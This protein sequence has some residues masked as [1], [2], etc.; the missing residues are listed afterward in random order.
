[1]CIRDSPYHD[2]D[3]FQRIALSPELQIILSN[4][5]EAGITYHEDDLAARPPASFPAQ[6]AQLLHDRYLAFEGSD[7]AG[8]AIICC[9]LIEENGEALRGFVVR[10][11]ERAGW[12]EE[13][14]GW[15]QRANHFYDTL[16]DRI[17]SGFPA[18]DAPTLQQEVGFEDRALVKGEFFSLWVIGGDPGLRELLPLD[19]LDLGVSYVPREDVYKRQLHM[20]VRI[21]QN[22]KRPRS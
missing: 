22:N 9:E 8:L 3:A 6:I 16:V 19:Q 5:T 11:A 12:G 7:A 17:V 18:D 15:L 14:L 1:M 10:H 2:Y 13:F 20:K 4:T 21:S